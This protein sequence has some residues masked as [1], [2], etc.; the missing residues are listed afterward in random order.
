VLHWGIPQY[1]AAMPLNVSLDLS[2]EELARLRVMGTE[3]PLLAKIEHAVAIA[4][5]KVDL[6]A[7]V[8]NDLKRFQEQRDELCTEATRLGKIVR[9]TG[10]TIEGIHALRFLA[11]THEQ[12]S[13]R[14][15]PP[16]EEHHFDAV[17]IGESG[18]EAF[19][20]KLDT[21]LE[22]FREQSNAFR[23]VRTCFLGEQQP[24][25]TERTEFSKAAKDA[26]FASMELMSMVGRED[27]AFGRMA[28]SD[29]I[30]MLMYGEG[31]YT[32]NRDIVATLYRDTRC[33]PIANFTQAMHDAATTL[34]EEESLAW[35]Q[36]RIEAQKPRPRVA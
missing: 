36:Q 10:Y 26:L 6:A 30:D 21:N 32:G 8:A 3:D 19:K 18:Y 1:A 14:L 27:H 7:R 25:P 22:F 9:K 15:G 29:A 24:F 34:R 20:R 33:Q 31:F 17:A 13:Y 4:Q 2:P 28:F 16:V 12:H 5:A 23:T 11:R 35:Q